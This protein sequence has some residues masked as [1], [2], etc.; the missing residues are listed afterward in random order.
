MGLTPH[1]FLTPSS[2]RTFSALCDGYTVN[3]ESVSLYFLFLLYLY[4]QEREAHTEISIHWFLL[5]CL[6]QLSMGHMNSVIKCL[7]LNLD[8]KCRCAGTWAHLLSF[9]MYII[10]KLELK[11]EPEHRLMHSTM[12][13]RWPTGH[14]KQCATLGALAVL[15]GFFVCLFVFFKF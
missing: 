10:R 13:F 7:N 9:S 5:R 14:V 2:T 6:L 4:L 3:E 8:L 12:E 15:G 1:P 11:L